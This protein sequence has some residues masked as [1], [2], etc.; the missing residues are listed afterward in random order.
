VTHQVE[1]P[2]ITNRSVNNLRNFEVQRTY[3]QG[4][5]AAEAG[6]SLSFMALLVIPDLKLRDK[7]LF[8]SNVFNFVL[9]CLDTN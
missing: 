6:K 3:W 9:L 4:V 5:L 2:A 7:G 8:S 1:A